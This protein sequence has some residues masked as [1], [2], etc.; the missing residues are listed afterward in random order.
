MV[1]KCDEAKNGTQKIEKKEKKI[2]IFEWFHQ[3]EFVNEQLSHTIW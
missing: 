3:N 2:I 1:F